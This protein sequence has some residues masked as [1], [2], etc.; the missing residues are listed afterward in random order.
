LAILSQY[1]IVDSSGKGNDK[2][3]IWDYFTRAVRQF[4]LLPGS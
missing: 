4:R 3:L 2:P 1:G